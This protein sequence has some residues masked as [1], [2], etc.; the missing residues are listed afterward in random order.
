MNNTIYNNYRRVNKA[1]ARKVFKS[2]KIVFA[3]P[4]NMRID[5]MW[6]PP[7]R[8][9]AGEHVQYEIDTYGLDGTFDRVLNAITYYNCNNETGK[10]LAYYVKVGI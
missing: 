3:L 7:F 10:Y 2:G 9:Y 1:A 8:V 5:N 4:V 6:M